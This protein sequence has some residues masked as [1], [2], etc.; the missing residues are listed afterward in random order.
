M[1]DEIEQKFAQAVKEFNENIVFLRQLIKGG[2]NKSYGIQVAR[3]AGIPRQIIAN[4][5]NKLSNIE[6]NSQSH[7]SVSIPPNKSKKKNNNNDTKQLDLF[8]NNQNKIIQMIDKIDISSMTPIEA[9]NLLNDLKQK[10]K[11]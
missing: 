2:T 5:N 4:A 11:L 8:N 10:I 7:V 9:L 3:L 6:Q 1:A